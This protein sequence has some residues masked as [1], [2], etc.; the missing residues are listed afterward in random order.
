M[1]RTPL[2][3]G[4]GFSVAPALRDAVKDRSCLVCAMPAVDPAHLIDRSLI[5]DHGDPRAVVPL[6]RLHHAAYDLGRLDLL[7]YLEPRHR[8]EL[9]FAVERFGLLRTLERVTGERWTPERKKAA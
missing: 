7:P 3:P 5:A 6:C 1:K 2:K 9:A 8:A 4:R